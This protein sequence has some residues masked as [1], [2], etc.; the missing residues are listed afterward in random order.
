MPDSVLKEV[1]G[2]MLEAS[3]A[4]PPS[5]MEIK[6]GTALAPQHPDPLPLSHSPLSLS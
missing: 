1:L 6:G 3:Q 2:E 5:P 4:D